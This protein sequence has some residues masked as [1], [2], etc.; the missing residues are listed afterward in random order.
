MRLEHKLL[1]TGYHYVRDV[2]AHYLFAQWP[3]GR[4]CEAED[5]SGIPWEISCADFAVRAQQLA[6]TSSESTK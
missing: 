1:T 2:E 5:V 3:V 4:P 6:D